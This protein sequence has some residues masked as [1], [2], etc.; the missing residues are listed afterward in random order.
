MSYT[1]M[2]IWVTHEAYR[3]LMD[4]LDSIGVDE[5]LINLD[6]EQYRRYCR[7]VERVIASGIYENE[8]LRKELGE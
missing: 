5:R 7:A 1:L 4:Y 6:S 8:L 2:S 3:T